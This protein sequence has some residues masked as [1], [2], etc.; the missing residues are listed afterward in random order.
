[1]SGQRHVA[2]L[3]RHDFGQWVEVEGHGAGWLY[4]VH[5]DFHDGYPER[6]LIVVTNEAGDVA[7]WRFTDSDPSGYPKTMSLPV[8][9]SDV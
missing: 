4:A 5:D 8:E 7:E 2:D 6:T 3:T 1:M 9:V